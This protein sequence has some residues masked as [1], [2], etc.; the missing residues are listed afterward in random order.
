VNPD[1]IRLLKCKGEE[2]RLRRV[3][4]GNG[5]ETYRFRLLPALRLTLRLLKGAIRVIGM[6]RRQRTAGAALATAPA[7]PEAEM[8]AYS[9][10]EALMRRRSTGWITKI[11][12]LAISVALFVLAFAL[13]LSVHTV[14]ILA[15]ILLFH[16]LGMRL[17][18]YRDVQILFLPFLGAIALADEPAV[19]AYQRVIVYLLG[20]L[21][22]LTLGYGLL[23][24]YHYTFFQ[25]TGESLLYETALIALTVNYFNLLP[26][27]PLDGGQVLNVVLFERW[28]RAQIA[29]LALSAVAAIGGG[30]LIGSSVLWLLAV[31]LLIALATEV[32]KAGAWSRLKAQSLPS[33]TDE[34]ALLQRVLAVLREPP[35]GR[36]SFPRRFHIARDLLRRS[37]HRQAML[38]VAGASLAVYA[39]ALMLP[40]WML[41]AGMLYGNYEKAQAPLEQAVAVIAHDQVTGKYMLPRAESTLGWVRLLRGDSVQARQ[42]FLLAIDHQEKASCRPQRNLGLVPL[43][44][45]LAYRRPQ[46]RALGQQPA[47]TGGPPEVARL[48]RAAQYSSRRQGSRSSSSQSSESSVSSPTSSSQ[49]S[50]LV[51]RREREVP[52]AGA[53]SRRS[54]GRSSGR[55][56]PAAVSSQSSGASMASK[57]S[58]YQTSISICSTSPSKYCTSTVPASSSTANTSKRWSLSSR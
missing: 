27:M 32:R 50:V 13:S 28:P 24:L 11:G 48:H 2:E 42:W 16:V 20:P 38:P 14:L 41:H 22:G 39:C 47:E 26:I 55:S 1:S 30:W 10:M 19:P 7:T 35:H 8:E 53:C 34:A 37:R 36:L 17:F 56:P 6:R 5:P 12:L 44:L 4:H 45:D 23:M 52:L 33:P 49:S 51:L 54:S 58:P 21:P 25:H 18:G 29:F 57:S 46:L 9:R 3:F 43:L 15:S 31:L 40:L